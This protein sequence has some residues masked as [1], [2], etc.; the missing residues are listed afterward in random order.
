[1]GNGPASDLGD[2][3]A[4]KETEFSLQKCHGLL[5]EV[6]VRPTLLA[7]LD[8]HHALRDCAG[9]QS[10][11]HADHPHQPRVGRRSVQ[12]VE[13]MNDHWVTSFRV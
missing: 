3:I 12:F 11:V 7:R 8:R 1:M 10:L 2:L 13:I 6:S 9:A 4:N 5:N